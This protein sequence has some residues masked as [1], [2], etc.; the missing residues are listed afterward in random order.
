MKPE[1]LEGT[2]DLH[3]D[4]EAYARKLERISWLMDRAVT[5]PGTK[6]SVGLDALFGL[7]PF[8]GDILTGVVQASLVVGALSRYKVPKEVAARMVANVLIDVGAGTVPFLGDLFDVAYKA[9]TRNVKLLQPYVPGLE[10]SKLRI[11]GPEPLTVGSIIRG[12]LWRYLIPIALVLIVVL[13]LV[14]IGTVVV[15]RWLFGY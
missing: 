5:V 3:P 15:F 6:I 9:N 12:T 2:K 14:T 11:P 4:D 8:V 1:I 10:F 7:I 13:T